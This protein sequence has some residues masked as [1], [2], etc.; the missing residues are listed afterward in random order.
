MNLNKNLILIGMMAS[1]KT[2]IG[3][4]LAKRLDLKFFDTDFII[5]KKTKMK[6]AQIFEKK[7]EAKFR[8]LERKI[9]LNLL[10][11][12]QCVIS[13][14]GGAYINKTIRKVANKKCNTIWLYWNSKTIIDRINKK[15]NKR[16]VASSLGDNELKNLLINRSKFYSKAK[17]KINCE[18]MEKTE[19]INKI[20]EILHL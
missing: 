15:K 20:I 13:V 10:N 19:I 16:P 8:D 11:K 14:G 18:N 5:E 1:G 2:S 12:K 6:I 3:R 17:Y 4:L 7:G 9:T